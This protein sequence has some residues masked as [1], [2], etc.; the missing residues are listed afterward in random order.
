MRV[1]SRQKEVGRVCRACYLAG[2][3]INNI[4]RAPYVLSHN[5]EAS[6]DEADVTKATDDVIAGK[7]K[8]FMIRPNGEL[9]QQES[10][11]R[12]LLVLSGSFN[13]LHEGHIEL[14]EVRK[15]SRYTIANT[16]NLILRQRNF[17]ALKN[18]SHLRFR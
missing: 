4:Q 12:N 8:C 1:L 11:F 17:C 9:S 16:I 5:M 7:R 15:P 6:I 2:T 14:A 18:R 3:G 10:D 13:P